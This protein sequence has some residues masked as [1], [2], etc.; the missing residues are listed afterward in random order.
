[1]WTRTA[2]ESRNGSIRGSNHR[3]R[4][5]I[6]GIRR[7]ILQF[8]NLRFSFFYGLLRAELYTH[9]DLLLAFG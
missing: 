4:M 1:M 5:R 2:S 8:L 7:A 6:E 9:G 3:R